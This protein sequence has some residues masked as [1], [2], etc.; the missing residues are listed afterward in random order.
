[1]RSEIHDTDDFFLRMKKKPPLQAILDNID[2]YSVEQLE[3]IQGQPLWIREQLVKLRRGEDITSKRVAAEAAAAK[4]ISNQKV[5]FP[6]QLEIRQWIGTTGW[7]KTIRWEVEVKEG[8]LFLILQEGLVL[9][10]HSA[11]KPIWG[12]FL[13]A[14]TSL[15]YGT[16]MDY[17]RRLEAGQPPAVDTT[18]VVQSSLPPGLA[19]LGVRIQ[20]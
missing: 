11:I 1:M 17:L 19:A 20:R 3:T 4:M 9:W 5:L 12:D 15:G 7:L 2:S 10:G 18:N 8:D 14:T 13:V 6:D 16:K